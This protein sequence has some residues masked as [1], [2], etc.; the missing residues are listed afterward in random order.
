MSYETSIGK[1][2]S[3]QVDYLISRGME[4]REAISL[5]ICGF[6]D[7]DIAGLGP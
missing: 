1:T 6:L 5:I 4:E 3:E 2:V 7:A